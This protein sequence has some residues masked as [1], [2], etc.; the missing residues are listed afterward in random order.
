MVCSGHRGTSHTDCKDDSDGTDCGISADRLLASVSAASDGTD[1]DKAML[2]VIVLMVLSGIR[3]GM[4]SNASMIVDVVASLSTQLREFNFYLASLKNL[5]RFDVTA[6]SKHAHIN[7]EI[8][9][10]DGRHMERHAHC[11][12]PLCLLYD[13]LLQRPKFALAAN[14]GHVLPCCFILRGQRVRGVA[15]VWKLFAQVALLAYSNQCVR[16]VLGCHRVRRAVRAPP[17]T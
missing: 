1:V 2:V 16:C 6:V 9:A 3:H 4:Y 12:S 17:A 15:D 14:P 11:V 13:I 8:N 10:G 5:R 7:V